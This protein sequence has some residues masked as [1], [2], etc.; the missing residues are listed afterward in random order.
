MAFIP[1]TVLVETGVIAVKVWRATGGVVQGKATMQAGT[2]QEGHSAGCKLAVRAYSMRGKNL[3]HPVPSMIKAP[4]ICQHACV[5]HVL[6]GGM[7]MCMGPGDSA[8]DHGQAGSP[9]RTQI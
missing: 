6:S 3:A 9:R 2:R 8:V 5:T 7:C 4:I 1:R